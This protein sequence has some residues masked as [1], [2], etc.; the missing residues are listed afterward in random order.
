LATSPFAEL[1]NGK[2][3]VRLAEKANDLFRDKDPNALAVLGVAQAEYGSF[4]RAID[5]TR[6]AVEIYAKAND[7]IKASAL[8]SRLTLFEHNKPY[9]DE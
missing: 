2:E 8:T 6:R 3:A 7:A 5:A 1:R 4:R 9:R